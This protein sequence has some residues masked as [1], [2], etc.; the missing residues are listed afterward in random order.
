MQILK[1][2]I[3]LIPVLS[4]PVDEKVHQKGLRRATRDIISRN[5]MLNGVK[6]HQASRS[7][8]AHRIG[9][10]EYLQQIK[11]LLNNRSTRSLRGLKIPEII[12]LS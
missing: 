3:L 9:E 8:N 1:F 12:R 7:K 6:L 10:N 5:R 11:N 4:L 2:F